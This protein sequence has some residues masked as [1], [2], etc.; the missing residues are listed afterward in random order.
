MRA[1]LLARLVLSGVVLFVGSVTSA[2]ADLIE[3]NLSS[4]VNATFANLN[5]VGTF[6]AFDP[7]IGNTMGNQGTGIPF[8]V[9]GTPG[10]NNYWL[11]YGQTFTVSLGLAA[12]TVYT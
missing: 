5:G 3:I 1:R 11:G 10:S 2:Y 4:V 12:T 7:T 9:A 8:L 6:T